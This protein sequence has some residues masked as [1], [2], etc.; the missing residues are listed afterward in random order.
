MILCVCINSLFSKD[1]NKLALKI[2]APLTVLAKDMER[3]SLLDL[4]PDFLAKPP[5]AGSIREMDIINRSFFKM[6]TGI[7]SFAK[8][9]HGLYVKSVVSRCRF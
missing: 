6:K 9:I 1:S 8:V 4:T 5:P 2:T 7:G 3:I